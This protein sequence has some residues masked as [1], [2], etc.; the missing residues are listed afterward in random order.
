MIDSSDGINYHLVLHRETKE[1]KCQSPGYKAGALP[2]H[3][4]T[5][6]LR[7]IFILGSPPHPFPEQQGISYSHIIVI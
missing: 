1:E 6:H 5:D 3:N 4:L 2:C 7:V